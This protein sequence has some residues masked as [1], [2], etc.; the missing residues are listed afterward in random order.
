MDNTEKLKQLEKDIIARRLAGLQNN[1][2]TW[3]DIEPDDN[4]VL[5]ID[6]T[7]FKLN[8]EQPNVDNT[9]WEY[10]N[11]L[12]YRLFGDDTPMQQYLTQKQTERQSRDNA[13]YNQY[14]AMQN[15]AEQQAEKE[16]EQRLQQEKEKE[17]KQQEEKER[18]KAKQIAKNNFRKAVTDISTP[19]SSI[20][21]NLDELNSN[22]YLS[23]D[24]Y[25]QLKFDLEKEKPRRQAHHKYSQYK[26]FATNDEKQ[27]ILSS[28][29]NDPYLTEDDKAE[30]ENIITPIVSLVDQAKTNI[31]AGKAGQHLGT[32]LDKNMIDALVD[33]AIKTGVMP[34]DQ[35]YKT[36]IVK[37][38]RAKGYKVKGT[39]V[40]KR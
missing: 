18:E 34:E 7:Y 21:A 27:K 15:K 30:L 10:K 25:E 14:I 28:I 4:G 24:E 13:I 33:D 20:I 22:G 6:G 19:Y 9:D 2:T 40:V 11:A 36:D 16:K 35:T 26:S 1:V 29:K 3:K 17:T 32:Q 8:N 39:K 37:G 5:D 12:M 38:L 31:R 23:K